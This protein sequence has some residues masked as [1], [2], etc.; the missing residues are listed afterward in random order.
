VLVNTFGTVK[1]HDPRLADIVRENFQLT[2]AGMI[3]ELDLRKPIYRQTAAFGH[4]GRGEDGFTWERTNRAE[5]L[6]EAAQL[7][8]AAV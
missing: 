4:F 5:A 8:S 2:P 1:I 7:T 3:K 6:R